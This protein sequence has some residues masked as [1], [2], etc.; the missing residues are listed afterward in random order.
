MKVHPEIEINK[1]QLG[2]LLTGLDKKFYQIII[3][4]NVFCSYCNSFAFKGIFV[5]KIY[6]TKVNDVKIF[7]R[8]KIC[9][10]EV[11]R[12]FEFGNEE[13]FRVKANK[14]RESIKELTLLQV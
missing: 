5:D 8:C 13:E 3:E 10:T 1:F 6:L 7:G 9:K 12:F 14:L 4:N 11:V 2:V